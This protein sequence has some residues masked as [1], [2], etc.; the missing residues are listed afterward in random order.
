MTR[1]KSPTISPIS[2]TGQTAAVGYTRDS[3]L[4]LIMKYFLTFCLLFLLAV[5]PVF[6]QSKTTTNQV[7]LTWD[8]SPA[9]ESVTHY[10]L[11][12]TTNLLSDVDITKAVN[13]AP[14][15]PTNLVTAS[16]NGWKLAL[17]VTNIV[18]GSLVTTNPVVTVPRVAESPMFFV[19]TAVNSQGL[20]S[21]FSNVAWVSIAVPS[22]KDRKLKIQ[23]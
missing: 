20:E 10:R 22:Y 18:N 4:F 19:V 21:P 16:T 1:W 6:G 13:M 2:Q 5:V 23:W 17:V 3:F 9:T 15:N 8:Q 11:F 12:V 14:N 7:T